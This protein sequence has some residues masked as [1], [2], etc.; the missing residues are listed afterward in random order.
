MRKKKF[1]VRRHRAY[2]PAIGLNN[3]AEV[4]RNALISLL[5]AAVFLAAAG[6]IIK[7]FVE[8][9]GIEFRM[10]DIFSRPAYIMIKE[11]VRVIYTDGRA[12]IIPDEMGLSSFPVISGVNVNEKREEHKKA[13]KQALKIK[14]RYLAGISEIIINDPDNIILIT[15]DGKK[16]YAG[17]RIDN[18]KMKRYKLVSDKAGE[19]GKRYSAIDMRYK[20]RVIIK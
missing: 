2:S 17:D 20:N 19:L 18:D 13:L 10:P 4:L 14:P 16:I 5:V 3:I 6:V 11:D 15:L 12:E 7:Y 9:N 1:F 8:K